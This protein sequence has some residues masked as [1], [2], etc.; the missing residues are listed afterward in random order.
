[1][2]ALG[3]S[4]KKGCSGTR[5]MAKQEPCQLKSGISGDTYDGDGFGSAHFKRDSIFCWSARR[6]FLLEV[7]MRTVSSPAIV[8][9]ISGNFDASTAAARGWAP[10][11]GVFRTSMFSAGRTS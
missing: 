8:P 3:I 10:L 5:R 2:R 9:A 6:V 4:H 7:M 11:G 1:M